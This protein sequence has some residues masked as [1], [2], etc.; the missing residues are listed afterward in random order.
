MFT[1]D[2]N[3]P[4]AGNVLLQL[5]VLGFGLLQDGDVRGATLNPMRSSVGHDA[6][7]YGAVPC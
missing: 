5:R 3:D 7:L 4:R 2:G 1:H 6:A